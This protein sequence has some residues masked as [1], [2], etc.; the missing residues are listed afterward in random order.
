MKTLLASA[1]LVALA[2]PAAAQDMM[3]I[4]GVA[5][6]SPDH[7]T[8]VA[9]VQA[10]DLVGTLQGEGPFTV[11]APT[12]AAFDALPAGVVAS[13][14]QPQNR[15]RLVQILTCHVVPAEVMSAQ[16][17]ALIQQG[18]GSA[19]IETVGGCTITAA[20]QDGN[21]VLT[22]EQG[23]RATVTA[24]DLDASNGVIHVIDDVL[25]PAADAQQ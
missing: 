23:R 25:L 10:A 1:A 21:V 8:L 18:G 11:F 15:D 9:A 22:D 13:L 2:L 24:V 6:G 5:S 20:V 17:A 4:V 12:N 14:L 7:T 16:V 3:D 19:A